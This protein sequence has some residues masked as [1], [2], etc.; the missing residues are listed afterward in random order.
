MLSPHFNLVTGRAG[1]TQNRSRAHERKAENSFGG[2]T[3][4][5]HRSIRHI[6]GPPRRK[7]SRMTRPPCTN[8]S[9]RSGRLPFR[10]T[11]L[12]AWTIFRVSR[13]YYNA[14][15]KMSAPADLRYIITSGRL[16]R[17]FPFQDRHGIGHTPAIPACRMT[18]IARRRSQQTFAPLCVVAPSLGLPASLGGNCRAQPHQGTQRNARRN[19]REGEAKL[20]ALC[21]FCELSSNWKPKTI[22]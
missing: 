1:K 21:A 2:L 6:N 5:T 8:C 7:S 15:R 14:Y 3:I 13:S 19:R 9:R 22:A 10:L 17:T 18:C 4:Y 11:T 20:K 16:V 12:C